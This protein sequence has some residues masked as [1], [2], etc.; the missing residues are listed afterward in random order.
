MIPFATLRD[1]TADRLPAE[2]IL[3]VPPF[4]VGPYDPDNAQ[5]WPGR[6]VIMSPWT[7]G[8]MTT[9]K[10]FDNQ[11]WMIDVLG[12]QNNFDDAYDI[13][14][15]IDKI[16]NRVDSTQDVNGVQVNSINRAGGGPNLISFEPASSRYHFNCPYIVQ[17]ASGI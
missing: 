11:G 17:S 10:M 9:E 15:A 4:D 2:G 6:M 7:G 3:D 1:Y 8:P 14:V 16:W 5:R 12:E 13:A